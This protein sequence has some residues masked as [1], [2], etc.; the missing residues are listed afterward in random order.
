MEEQC[1]MQRVVGSYFGAM[2]MAAKSPAE[3]HCAQV[4]LHRRQHVS[5]PLANK[6][7]L[8]R[9]VQSV[10]RVSLVVSACHQMGSL[11]GALIARLHDETKHR[12]IGGTAAKS[13]LSLSYEK[14]TTHFTPFKWWLC[15][16]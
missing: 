7:H 2:S 5:V 11:A 13:L 1:G 9:K 4:T 12:L 8:L 10:E 15:C 6:L 14:D 3:R 16:E